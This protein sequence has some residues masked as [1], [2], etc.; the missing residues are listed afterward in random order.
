MSESLKNLA[1]FVTVVEHGGFANSAD[2][3]GITPSAV[4]KAVARLEE[5]LGTRL[6]TRST[7]SIKLTEPGQE[8]YQRGLSIL[9]AADE[10]E[11][12][13]SNLGADP[14]GELKVACSDAF[15]NL[16][17]VPMLER[18]QAAHPRIRIQI[19]QGDGPM[20]LVHER[21][22]VAIRFEKPEQKS[23]AVTNLMND[24]WVVCAAPRY[25]KQYPAPKKP[26]DLQEHRCL[27]IFARERL[28]DQWQFR[29][30]KRQ[31][32][33]IEPVFSGIGLVVKAAALRGLGVARLANFLVTEEIKQGQ[34]VP[35][36]TDYQLNDKRQIYVVTP[37]RN[38]I[39]AKTRVFVRALTQYL[40]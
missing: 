37:D 38:Y 13:V 16:I 9:A 17:L 26:T 4:S 27:S 11:T 3:L 31:L 10:A 2:E 1:L 15:A 32:I 28:D 14:Q 6:F 21:F 19:M 36:L 39:P 23:L 30:G 34:L 5:K 25:L 7:R 20:D 12:V 29:G 35:L 24:P 8:L 22:D 40:R 18:F 33:K